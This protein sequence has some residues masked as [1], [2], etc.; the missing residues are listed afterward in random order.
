LTLVLLASLFATYYFAQHR[1][2][3]D[4]TTDTL[5]DYRLLTGPEQ[6]EK[7]TISDDSTPE[8]RSAHYQT[9]AI[10]YWSSDKEKALSY[11]LMAENLTPTDK[12]LLYNIA[13]LYQ[14][15]GN[16]NKQ[17]EYEVKASKTVD[18]QKAPNNE[19]GVM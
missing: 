1:R 3:S 17:S 11:L 7:T 13:R 6:I 14:E 9:I 12:N 2:T 15:L 16:S 19:Q 8:Y 4:T 5:Q 18:K 10:A